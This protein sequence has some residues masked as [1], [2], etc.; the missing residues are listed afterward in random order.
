MVVLHTAGLSQ[1][2]IAEIVGVNRAT[3]RKAVENAATDA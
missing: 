2:Q 3:V 1:R